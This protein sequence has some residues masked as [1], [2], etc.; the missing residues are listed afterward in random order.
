M[1][2]M[3]DDAL[4]ELARLLEEREKADGADARATIDARIHERFG[5]RR[6]ILIT[7]MSGFSR[8]TQQLGIVHFLGMIERMK[9]LCARPIA[10]HGGRLVKT[11]GDDLFCSYETAEGAVRSAIAMLDVCERDAEGRAEGDKIHMAVGIGYG[12]VIDLDGLDLYGDEVNRASKLG[13]DIAEPGEILV[14]RAVAESTGAI[15]GW[16]FEQRN[17]RISGITFDYYAT[18]RNR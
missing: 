10:E 8:T 2:P 12:S 7:D 17:A 15:K 14:T 16:W 4:S 3:G 18:T 11:I 13:E 9:R 6:A 1:A 5:A